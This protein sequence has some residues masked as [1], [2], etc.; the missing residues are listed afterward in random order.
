MSAL[1]IGAS[2][3]EMLTGA[4]WSSVADPFPATIWPQA[5][6]RATIG[7]LDLL[8]LLPSLLSAS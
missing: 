6:M 7:F 2:Q 1:L 3:A 4:C 5:T 8:L